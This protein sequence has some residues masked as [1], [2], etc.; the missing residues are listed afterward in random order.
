M[1][2]IITIAVLF[3]NWDE[4]NIYNKPPHFYSVRQQ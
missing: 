1:L 4:K 3:A 2:I